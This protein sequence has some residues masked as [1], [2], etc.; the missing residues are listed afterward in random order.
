MKH[1][2]PIAG[3]RPLP[4]PNGPGEV[5][6]LLFD[7]RRE[8]KDGTRPNYLLQRWLFRNTITDPSWSERKLENIFNELILNDPKYT[9]ENLWNRYHIATKPELDPFEEFAEDE[10]NRIAKGQRELIAKLLNVGR[11]QSYRIMDNGTTIPAQAKIL[12]AGI[13]GTTEA[14]WM[15]PALPQG[16]K[17]P[18]I[19]PAIKA[20]RLDGCSLFDFI[21][22]VARDSKFERMSEAVAWLK[23]AYRSDQ[24]PER[25]FESFV[26]FK[27]ALPPAIDFTDAERVWDGFKVWRVARITEALEADLLDPRS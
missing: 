9:Y 13:P 19:A 20:L 16:R 2:G 22:S 27:K 21:E 17:P 3:P 1:R 7:A 11:S 10:A 6:A 4:D 25:H 23:A 14:E 24:S 5:E 18:S 12:A 8:I 15:R 26:Q